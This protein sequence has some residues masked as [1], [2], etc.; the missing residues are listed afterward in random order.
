MKYICTVSKVQCKFEYKMLLDY[1]DCFDVK[2]LSHQ[3]RNSHYKEMMDS[4]PSYLCNWITYT[5]E[6]SFF[7]EAKHSTDLFWYIPA[8]DKSAQASLCNTFCCTSSPHRRSHLYNCYLL[9]DIPCVSFNKPFNSLNWEEPAQRVWNFNG[10]MV[11][12][13][14]GIHIWMQLT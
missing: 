11:K 3:K 13:T 2:I 7:I 5:S 14:K 8:R 4:W 10:E 9:G 12:M 6:D 1:Q